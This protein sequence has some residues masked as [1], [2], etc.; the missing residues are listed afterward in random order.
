MTPPPPCDMAVK[1]VFTQLLISCRFFF[2]LAKFQKYRFYKPKHYVV[3]KVFAGQ[4]S[5][6]KVVRNFYVLSVDLRRSW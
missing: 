6:I 2:L 3:E 4:L 5:K 1:K